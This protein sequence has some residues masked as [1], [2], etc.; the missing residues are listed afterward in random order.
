MLTILLGAAVR[1][2]ALLALVSILLKTL[3]LRDPAVEKNTWTLVVAAALVMPLLSWVTGAAAAPLKLL[4]LK[5]LLPASVASTAMLTGVA[6]GVPGSRRAL[7]CVFVYAVVTAVLLTRF[8][9]GLWMGA[10]LLRTAS[11]VSRPQS[12]SIDVRVSAA[13]LSPASF[14][15]TILLP[16]VYEAWDK[17]TLET[18]LAHEQAHIRNGDCYRLWLAALYRAIFWFDPLAHWLHWRLRVLSELTSDEAAAAALGDRAA[19]AATLK[20]VTS[21]SQFI[22]STVAMA[23]SR[24]LARRL[25]RLLSQQKMS[26]PLTRP[27]RAVLISAVLVLVVLAAVP[28]A[29]AMAP[30]PRRLATPELHLVDE[31]NSPVPL[32]ANNQAS[33]SSVGATAQCGDGTFF[34]GRFINQISCLDHGGVQ[35]RLRGSE[36]VL[37]R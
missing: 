37:V 11:K 23:D 19:Y 31:Q 12:G 13:I 33:W 26:A 18:V 21:P 36:T 8:M 28:G 20:Q 29:G 4:P 24:S 27:R 16:P 15:S 25:G 14:G 3:R 17:A 6:L 34:H 30:V 35:F 32:S 2:G 1:G 9:I 5:L 22:P 10:R 7:V